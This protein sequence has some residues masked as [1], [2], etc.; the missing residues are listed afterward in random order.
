MK[1]KS[2]NMPLIEKFLDK[3]QASPEEKQIF[4][5]V[6]TTDMMPDEVHNANSNSLRVG[7]SLDGLSSIQHGLCSVLTLNHIFNIPL[8][9]LMALISPESVWVK[10]QLYFN[11]SQSLGPQCS[12]FA[13]NRHTVSVLHGYEISS[14]Q[15]KGLTSSILKDT[16]LEHPPFKDSEVGKKVL[17]REAVSNNAKSSTL[18]GIGNGGNNEQNLLAS[19]LKRSSS[20]QLSNPEGGVVKKKVKRD[21]LFDALA[22]SMKAEMDQNNNTAL[23]INN[24]DVAD[25]SMV[26]DNNGADSK[27]KSVERDDDFGPYSSGKEIFCARPCLSLLVSNSPAWSLI[28]I[29]RI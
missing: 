15:Y 4:R 29:Y 9:K 6:L 22:L 18:G 19:A 5:F 23:P 1:E 2:N 28:Q 25:D 13:L 16:L 10:E 17:K 11:N 26:E 14:A 21:R 7:M 24:N 20:P 8:P 27:K 12:I 3:L